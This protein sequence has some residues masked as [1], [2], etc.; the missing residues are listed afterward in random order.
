MKRKATEMS[1]PL[2]KNMALPEET[3]FRVVSD[4]NLHQYQEQVNFELTLIY[5]NPYGVSVSRSAESSF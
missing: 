1:E 4:E 2:E 3:P 5:V